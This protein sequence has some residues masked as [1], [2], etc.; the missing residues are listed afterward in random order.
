MKLVKKFLAVCFLLFG[1]PLSAVIILELLSPKTPAKEK[2][3]YVTALTIFTIPSTIVGGWLSWSLVQ[4]NRKE[5][6][7]LIESEQKRLQLALLE[8]IEQNSGR[9]TVLQLAKN[10]EISTQLAKQY[11]DD[12]AK[13]LNAAFEVNEEGNVLYHFS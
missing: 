1:I 13:E 11:L 3:N 4:Q 5:K 2:E 7:L 8:L 6:A 12:K 10:A 9:V